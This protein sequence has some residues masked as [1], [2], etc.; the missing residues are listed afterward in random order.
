MDQREQ[1]IA[2]KGEADGEPK[3]TSL[4]RRMLKS[5]ESAHDTGLSSSPEQ[6]MIHKAKMGSQFRGLPIFIEIL[7]KEDLS[8]S[9][10]VI[11]SLIVGY[12]PPFEYTNKWLGVILDKHPDS[13]S[14]DITDLARKGYL[15]REYTK[16]KKIELRL[17]VAYVE[18]RSVTF[19]R[20]DLIALAERYRSYR[21]SVKPENHLKKLPNDF[22]FVVSK[23]VFELHGLGLSNKIILGYIVSLCQRNYMKNRK[24]PTHNYCRINYGPVAQLFNLT[25]ARVGDV[26]RKLI[27]LDYLVEW[28]YKSK[29]HTKFLRADA[30][31]FYDFSKKGKSKEDE[32]PKPSWGRGTGGAKI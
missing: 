13:V 6:A 2:G 14:K 18:R 4:Q 20:T 10:K 9:E 22:Y 21:H 30:T 3:L 23:A 28:Y 5:F 32:V 31:L 26:V 17:S 1:K 8:I 29:S 12:P 11:L 27:R 19:S 15:D 7:G 25:T 24:N 16:P